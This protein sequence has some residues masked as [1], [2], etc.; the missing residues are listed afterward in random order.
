MLSL[1]VGRI[2]TGGTMMNKT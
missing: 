1:G 2:E